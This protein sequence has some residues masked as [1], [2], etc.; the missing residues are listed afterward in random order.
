MEVGASVFVRVRAVGGEFRGARAFRAVQRGN[1]HN[2]VSEW[3]ASAG[4]V[5]T[6]TQGNFSSL[7]ADGDGDATLACWAA[8]HATAAPAGPATR[9]GVGVRVLLVNGERSCELRRLSSGGGDDAWPSPDVLR[10]GEVHTGA[11]HAPSRRKEWLSRCSSGGDAATGSCS[12][13]RCAGFLSEEGAVAGRP[14][15]PSK[16]ARRC[17][18]RST[19]SS[20]E[21]PSA[22]LAARS[23]AA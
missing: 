22:S 12:G 4:R 9:R 11:T 2:T 7:H 17:S 5:T 10:A 1:E 16:P 6:P 20:L 21:A 15:G 13:A 8:P 14:A 3:G 23:S 18:A 19:A